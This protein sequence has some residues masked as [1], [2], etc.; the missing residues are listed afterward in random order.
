[1]QR[2][3]Q[4]CLIDLSVAHRVCQAGVAWAKP[5]SFLRAKPWWHQQAAICFGDWINS[6][7]YDYSRNGLGWGHLSCFDQLSIKL[8]SQASLDKRSSVL[9]STALQKKNPD[10]SALANS[11][12]MCSRRRSP[13]W[14]SNLTLGWC[15]RQI[16]DMWRTELA[17][18]SQY[19]RS[20]IK[21]NVYHH[22]IT[23]M[24]VEGE[25]QVHICVLGILVPAF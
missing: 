23:T 17:L 20:L 24:C 21:N 7:N 6:S 1:M 25:E 16:G 4:H 18:P 9:A 19:L 2:K 10:K 15:H 5:P 13:R 3:L 14:P 22:S 12:F 11:R 8:V